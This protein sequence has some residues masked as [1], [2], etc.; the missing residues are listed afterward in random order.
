MG[1]RSHSLLLL[2]IFTIFAGCVPSINQSENSTS[3][4]PD[5]NA[6]LD[7]SVNAFMEGVSK[8]EVSPSG[9]QPESASAAT[10]SSPE[11]IIQEVPV[12]VIKM[13]ETVLSLIHI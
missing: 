10:T 8:L 13:V 7:A 1:Y 2:V 11:I 9:T 3:A 12:E 5:I 4:T 6:T